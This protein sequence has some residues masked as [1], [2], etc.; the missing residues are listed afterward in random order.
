MRDFSLLSDVDFEAVCSDLLAAE[1]DLHYERFRRGKDGGVDLRATPKAGLEIVQCKHYMRSG[2]AKLLKD[3]ETES[4]KLSRIDS[5]NTYRV[6]TSLPLT[7]TEKE[8]IRKLFHRWMPDPG[9]VHSGQDIDSMLTRYGEVERRYVKLWITSGGQLERAL[10]AATYERSDELLRQISE[11][12]PR[13][14]EGSAF[15]RALEVLDDRQVCIISGPPGIGK[16]TLA[17]MLIA[18]AIR[19]GFEPIAVSND[20]EEA[21]HAVSSTSQQAFYYD[22]FLGRV[23]FSEKL[24]K[25]EDHR[26]VQFIERI[27]RSESKRLILTTREYVLREARRDFDELARLDEMLNLVIEMPD[28]SRLDRAKILYNH[29][30]H[31]DIPT[32]DVES[33]LEDQAYMRIIDHRNFSPRLIQHIT[34]RKVIRP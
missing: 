34:S 17:L 7:L 6:A 2:V 32:D 8:K 18:R 10:R 19:Q 27:S 28:Y 29:L 26:L 33:L 25:N 21:W 24:L 4:E 23:S 1:F 14:V 20:I 31:S 3:L 16:T 5:L 13:Y 15:G 9:Y 30:W 12:I 22:D 11:A